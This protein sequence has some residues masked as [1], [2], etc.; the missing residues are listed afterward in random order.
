[1]PAQL[2]NSKP[3]LASEV[4]ISSEQPEVVEMPLKG[5]ETASTPQNRSLAERLTARWEAV[6]QSFQV[7]TLPPSE[8]ELYKLPPED[9]QIVEQVDTLIA[10]GADWAF[11]SGIPSD[12]FQDRWRSDDQRFCSALTT[13]GPDGKIYLV[14]E[15]VGWSPVNDSTFS[16][17]WVG[18]AD[19]IRAPGLEEL[20]NVHWV[21]LDHAGKERFEVIRDGE[22]PTPAGD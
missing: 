4:F 11:Q 10:A 7:M 2:A 15:Y 1:M 20:T 14:R 13:R 12:A 3:A 16:A 9:R 21:R 18:S 19:E 8:R 5:A 6:M 17:Y 22:A